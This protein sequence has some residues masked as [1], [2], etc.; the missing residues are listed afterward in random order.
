MGPGTVHAATTAVLALQRWGLGGLL[1]CLLQVGLLLAE[2]LLAGP[3]LA[4]GLL[5]CLL[6]VGLLLA[7][8]LLVAHVQTD[9]GASWQLQ[10][11]VV[12]GPGL[13]GD[14]PGLLQTEHVAC[15]QLLPVW[16]LVVVGSGTA[17]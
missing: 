2:G 4:G 8:G 5:Q 13:P 1:Q 10:P 14:V 16:G 12:A 9:A 15:R 11:A 7:E 3:P 17:A 6:R